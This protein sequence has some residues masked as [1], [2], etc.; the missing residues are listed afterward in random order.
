MI[1]H[2]SSPPDSAAD[3]LKAPI[4]AG[5]W[6]ETLW[7]GLTCYPTGG[8]RVEVISPRECLDFGQSLESAPRLL[9]T[10][11]TCYRSIKTMDIL[12]HC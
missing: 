8:G 2:H 11:S 4:I 6:M 7:M 3:G 5:F 9:T 10:I 1:T 12:K